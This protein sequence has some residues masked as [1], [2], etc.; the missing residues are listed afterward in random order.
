VKIRK[1]A[2]SP[3]FATRRDGK[4]VKIGDGSTREFEIPLYATGD[5]G[6][7][8]LRLDHWIIKGIAYRKL[9]SNE[10]CTLLE[11][12]RRYDGNNN[13]NIAFGGADG[14]RIGL[15]ADITERAL[16]RL[17]KRRFIICTQAANP[18]LKKRRRWE[19]TMYGVGREKPKKLFMGADESAQSNSKMRIMDASLTPS[20][21]VPRKENANFVNDVTLG[22]ANNIVRASEKDRT[23][24]IRAGESHVETISSVKFA[25]HAK[26]IPPTRQPELGTQGDLFEADALPVAGTAGQRLVA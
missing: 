5:W 12:M 25:A 9:N 3:K 6:T 11:M 4:K 1:E 24:S 8:W 20:L 16:T 7:H 22:A 2:V 21:A 26:T 13:G 10:R 19:L 23:V 14:A 15:S 17:E 18:R